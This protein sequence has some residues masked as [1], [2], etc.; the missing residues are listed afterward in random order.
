MKRG[1]GWF[2][3]CVW[4]VGCTGAQNDPTNQNLETEEQT[5]AVETG[6]ANSTDTNSETE[7]LTTPEVNYTV[8]VARI[9]THG[10]RV[11]NQS[12]ARPWVD[13]TLEFVEA[14][15]NEA[16]DVESP[17]TWSGFGA[18]HIRGNSS[19]SYDKKQYTLEIRDADGNDM[20]ATFFGFPEEE[21]WVLAAPY[22]DKTLMRNHLMFQW[23]RSIGRYAPRTRFIEVYMEVDG[24]TIGPEDYRG[25][26]VLTEKVK[27]DKNRVNVEK[28]TEAD[29]TAPTVEGGY[30]LRRDWVEGNAIRTA[31]YRDQLMVEYPRTEDITTA[32]WSYVEEYL[33]AFESALDEGAGDYGAFIDVESFADHML[34]MELSRN[35]DAYVLSTYMHKSREGSLTMGPIWDF[36][37][38]LGNADYFQ[39]WMTAG[40][41]YE[42]PEFPADNPNGFKWYEKLLED[43][44]FTAILAERWALHRS[45]IWSTKSLMQEID[46]TVELINDAQQRNF[47][48][49]P[50][51][52]EY[53]WPN[54][55]GA[56]DRDSYIE[57][58][59]YLKTW[60]TDRVEWMDG[61]LMP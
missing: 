12:G 57:E 42:N 30:L 40:W 5:T 1:L 21:D 55:S 27:R 51:L 8:G 35:V 25:V 23:S 41:H 22:S 18:I 52:G 17:A 49:W 54:D 53:V 48:K 45:S 13:I 10:V 6:T 31:L 4:M 58:I 39:S 36:N 24:G 37:G 60:L 28:L 14:V 19:V 50:V 29:N 43:P 47:E 26:Y 3:L 16:V 7:T 38:S 2:S 59:E 9:D 44:G 15:D 34:M 56:E 20:D 32:Q 46:V 61:Q 11:D 33:N